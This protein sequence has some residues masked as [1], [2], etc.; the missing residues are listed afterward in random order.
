VYTV[1]ILS[2]VAPRASSRVRALGFRPERERSHPDPHSST[3]GVMVLEATILCLD[4]SE[5]VRNSDYAPTRLQVRDAR[6]DARDERDDR[7]NGGIFTRIGLTDDDG[8]RRTGGGGCGEFT[9]R[10]EDAE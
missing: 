9:R 1:R 10:C 6:D 4:N 8:S 2:Y 3:R 5:H 7:S